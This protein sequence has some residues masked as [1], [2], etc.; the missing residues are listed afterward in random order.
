VAEVVKDQPLPNLTKGQWIALGLITAVCSVL[1]VLIVR[2]A[3]LAIWP[4]LIMFAPLDSL[5]RA[6]LFT[7]VPALVAT[8]ILAWLVARNAQPVRRFVQIAIVVLLISV[9]PDYALPDP[10]RTLLASSVTAFLHVVAAVVTVLVL[11]SG[12][13]RLSGA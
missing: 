7:L 5:P 13:R 1:A 12:Y 3:A 6:G 8:A 11:V 10:H 2:A 9:I 4:D